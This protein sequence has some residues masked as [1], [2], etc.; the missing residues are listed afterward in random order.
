MKL[1]FNKNDKRYWTR[2][3][4]FHK[5]ADRS[6]SVSIQHGRERRRV[7]LRTADR[8][9]AGDLALKFYQRLKAS[10]WDEALRWWKG[11]LSEVKKSDVTVGEYIDAVTE[12]SIFRPKTLQSYVASLR[13]IVGDVGG[14]AH[15]RPRSS[16]RDRVSRRWPPVC[17][18]AAGRA[19]SRRPMRASK[20]SCC[21]SR[22]K[23]A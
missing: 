22:P 18:S 14:I 16:W 2:K 15:K 5:A 1:R 8:E 19:T 21:R 17:S 23:R 7:G 4:S 10:G 11:D 9:H 20:R 12:R 3:V 13:K 6:Y